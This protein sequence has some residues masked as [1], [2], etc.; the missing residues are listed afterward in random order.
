MLA[1]DLRFS[2]RFNLQ[3]LQRTNPGESWINTIPWC[4]CLWKRRRA[5]GATLI[6]DRR[7]RNRLHLCQAFFEIP[8]IVVQTGEPLPQ[9]IHNETLAQC[10]AQIEKLT[11]RLHNRA[12]NLGDRTRISR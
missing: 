2:L 11:T 7:F 12:R 3:S 6:L 9:G 8:Q 1:F 4:I 10:V 5:S